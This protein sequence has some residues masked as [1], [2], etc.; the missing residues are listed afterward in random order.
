MFLELEQT[1]MK[2]AKEKYNYTWAEGS[3]VHINIRVQT[4]EIRENCEV[5]TNIFLNALCLQEV[6][7]NVFV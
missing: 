6:V 2:V 4:G 1:V 7:T 3:E 5:E